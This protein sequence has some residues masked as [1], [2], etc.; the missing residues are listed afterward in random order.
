MGVQRRIPEPAPERIFRRQRPAPPP[1]LSSASCWTE[2]RLANA[3]T[4]VGNMC[5]AADADIF[6]RI[7]EVVE[8]ERIRRSRLR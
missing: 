4:M 3:P 1:A 5:A 2:S 6:G 8:A 7:V